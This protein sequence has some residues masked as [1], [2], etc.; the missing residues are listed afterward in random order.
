MQISIKARLIGGFALVVLLIVASSLL[1]IMRLNGMNERIDDI[2]DNSAES[3][4]LGA[5]INQ[6]LLWVSRGERNF[7]LASDQ[8]ERREFRNS[9]AE[10]R[11]N[12]SDRREALRDISDAEEIAA[13]DDFAARWEEYLEVQDRVFTLAEE[14]NEAE[15]FDLAAGEGRDL[16][17]RA[18]SLIT[19]IVAGTEEEL[20]SDKAASD[21]NFLAARNTLLIIALVS[22]S[23]SIAVAAW[24]V[25]SVNG[26]IRRALAVTSALE[27]GDLTVTPDIR[28]RDEI[29]TLLEQMG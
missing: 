3:I 2:V 25:L 10:A 15:A 28:N 16:L 6:D 4:K 12:L 24:V 29:G 20:E 14:G 1:A 7:L 22:L 19:E 13:L 21:A 8:A 5:R 26:G 18:E 27:Q 9:I 23:L 17:D 11:E